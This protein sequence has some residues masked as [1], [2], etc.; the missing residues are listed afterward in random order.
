MSN[1]KI[2][3][4]WIATAQQMLTVIQKVDKS[5]ERQEK[6]MQKLADTSKK[7]ADGAANSFNKLEQELKENEAALKKL[8]RGTRQFD[9]Q[10]KKVD[11]LRKSFKGAKDDLGKIGGETGGL[12]S[13]AVGK[14]ASLAVG[15]ASFQQIVSAVVAELEKTKTLKLEAAA[16]SRTFE[17]ALSD[18]GQ[19]IGAPAV[20]EARQMILEQAPILGTTTEGLA[21]LL[22]VAI[23]AGA[24]DLKEAL[25]LVSSALKVTV[26]D[27]QRARALVGGTLDV[28]SLGGSKNFE[29]ALGQLLQTQSQVRSTNLAE[30]SSNIGPGLAA[31]TANLSQQ[32]GVTTERALEIA[33][34]IS[35]IIKDQTG[36]NTATT[37]RMMFTRMGS[38]VP[39]KEVKLDDGGMAKV[40]KDQIAAFKSLDTFDERLKM[41]Q[42]VPAIG[43]QFLETQRESIG[44]TAIAEII[45]KEQRAVE[46]EQK[47]ATNIQSIDAAQPFLADLADTLARETAQLMTERRSQAN[48]AVSEIAGERDL[49]GTVQKVVEDTVAKVNLSGLDVETSGTIRDRMRVGGL[50]GET[51]IQ[52]GIRSLEEAKGQRKAFGVIPVGSQVSAEDKALIDRQITA[53]ENLE[54]T[55]RQAMPA[56][57][58]PRVQQAPAVRPKEAPL[59]AVTSP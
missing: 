4:E 41:M 13:S 29:G 53:L 26:G 48:I 59:P 49:E 36:S 14:V 3:V 40:T 20:P 42:T 39:E 16:T 37:M 23:S 11:E 55:L 5:L 32:K 57:Q 1:E 25:S 21:D 38:F 33:S 58:G 43:Q 52:T 17:Q 51:P 45:R 18:I 7:G 10:K 19:N 47:A 30:F 31:A 24:K 15:M 35:Q 34:V 22:G 56:A 27:A 9:E 2:E 12:L 50:L 46:F 44:K 8:E 28:A 6:A 54:A